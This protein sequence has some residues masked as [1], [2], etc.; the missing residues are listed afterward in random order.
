MP[1]TST[2][3]LFSDSHQSTHSEDCRYKRL[4]GQLSNQSWRLMW[5]S[6]LFSG[7]ILNL[8]TS[9]LL[10]LPSLPLA[11]PLVGGEGHLSWC[12]QWVFRLVDVKRLLECTTFNSSLWPGLVCTEGKHQKDISLSMVPWNPKRWVELEW[13][14]LRKVKRGQVRARRAF[15]LHRGFCHQHQKIQSSNPFSL[16]LSSSFFSPFFPYFSW[17]SKTS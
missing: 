14:I 7:N 16:H 15:H 12:K 8:P 3:F 6:S 5:T 9:S 2:L 4:G 17:R 1:P 13:E 11:S 10:G